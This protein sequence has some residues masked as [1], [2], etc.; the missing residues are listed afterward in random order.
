MLC[1][2]LCFFAFGF[3]YAD[4]GGDQSA[5]TLGEIVVYGTK[6]IRPTKQ[7]G[8]T[9]YTGTEVTKDGIKLSGEKGKGNVYE[10]M[11]I[12]P[13]VSFESPDPFNLSPEQTNVRIRGVRGYL[14]A[15]TVEGVPNYGGNPMGPR[16]YIYDMENFDSLAVYKGAVPGDLGS[17][18]GNRGGAVELRPK[19]AEKE[20]K[21]TFTQ[22]GGQYA[23]RRTYIRGD[24]GELGPFD[25]RA[26][27]AY[28]YTQS[29]KW[30]GPGDIGPRHNLNATLVQP[31]GELGE[32]KL[33]GNF[34]EIDSYKYRSLTYAQIQNFDAYYD[35]DFNDALTGKPSED[36]YYYKYN[37]EYHRNRDIFAWAT[38]DP[39]DFLS[40]SL[41]PYYSDE[42]ANIRD[43]VAGGPT[44][45]RVQKR[46]RDIERKGV[47]AESTFTH[48]LFK[49]TVGYHFEAADMNI[50]SRN[51]GITPNGL[52]YQGV[53]VMGTTGT[54]YIN[55]PYV[56][57]SGSLG[58]LNWQ[59]G[60]KYFHFKDSESEGYVSDPRDPWKL[61][62][63]PDLDREGRSYDIWLPTAG[64]SYAL[65][66]MVEAY[67]SYGKN[68]IRPYA[69]MPLV[70]LYSN[71]RAKFQSAG[72]TLNDLFRGYDMEES[73]NVD[74]GIRFKTGF[75][76]IMPTFFYAK[77]D[78]LLTT[79][80]DPRVGL[81]YQQNIGK[82]TGYGVELASSFFVSDWLTLFINPTYQHL[83]YDDDITYQGRTLETEGKQVVDTPRWMVVTG[84]IAKFGDFTVTPRMRYI[85]KRYGD[86]EH[87]EEVSSYPVFDLAVS[88]SKKELGFSRF[89]DFSVTLEVDNILDKKYV[90]VINAMDDAMTGA[91]TYLVGAPMTVKASVSV[92]F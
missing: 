75:A 21:V 87:K 84:A 2:L 92:A 37:R 76:E 24:S 88:Y 38:L 53:G 30:K 91:T 29:D 15:M 82:A 56:K 10:V 11:S 83:T 45:A 4:E 12:L 52:V 9:V 74:V 39:Y 49:T 54:T 27:L 70:T 7:L 60:V 40:F 67:V 77:H 3:S 71:N 89:Q 1:G 80:Y 17:G 72:I 41:K 25:T 20:Q 59:A 65:T 36:R 28:S 47:I 66:D 13:G 33:F 50:T 79:V 19:W 57:L 58:K 14:G 90:A 85:G 5:T 46:I 51:Y 35:L 44:G 55:S 22:S 69:Y 81:N 78:K 6:I 64:L 68:F 42:D 73:D 63:A 8:E 26:S 16:A 61:V 18:V 32:V 86:A 34:N 43:G 62:R 48:S 31:L 23:Y